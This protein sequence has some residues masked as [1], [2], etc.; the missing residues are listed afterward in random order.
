MIEARSIP[1][2]AILALPAAVLDPSH[3]G[4][5]ANW[6]HLSRRRTPERARKTRNSPDEF[7]EHSASN[8]I[9]EPRAARFEFLRCFHND[10]DI[11]VAR[12]AR[13]QDG[14]SLSLEA[15]LLAG[16]CALRDFHLGIGPVDRRNGHV[17]ARAAVTIAI[18]TRQKRSAPSRWKNACGLRDRKM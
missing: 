13:P 7:L 14:H 9:A 12:I 10:L 16:L 17:A 1:Q 11:E 3:N 18:G 6:I 4:S 8:S 15:E 5:Q 2:V